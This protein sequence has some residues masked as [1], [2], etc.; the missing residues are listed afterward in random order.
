MSGGPKE[1]RG[2][3]GRRAQRPHRGGRATQSR[4]TAKPCPNET[5]DR[6]LG[7]VGKKLGLR[8]DLKKKNDSARYLGKK[9]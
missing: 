2:N 4:V 7:G 9:G 5:R 1:R 6:G 3:C 8:N